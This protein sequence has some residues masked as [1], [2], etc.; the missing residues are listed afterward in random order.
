MMD[1]LGFNEAPTKA[2]WRHGTRNGSAASL[3]VK[4]MQKESFGE[5]KNSVGKLLSSEQSEGKSLKSLR[6]RSTTEINFGEKNASCGITIPITQSISNSVMK[7]IYYSRTCDGNQIQ[8]VNM[9]LLAN[10]NT[11]KTLMNSLVLL[12]M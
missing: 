2:K 7:V 4:L 5:W 3:D 8:D 6:A 9:K 12:R 1:T 11:W 10:R